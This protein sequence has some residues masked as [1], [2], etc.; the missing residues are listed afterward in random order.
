MQGEVRLSNPRRLF[1]R[2]VLCRVAKAP[3]AEEQRV[4]PSLT[5]SCHEVA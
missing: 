5:F 2:S 3:L 1:A 4:L